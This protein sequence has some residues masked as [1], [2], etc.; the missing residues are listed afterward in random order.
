MNERV[1]IKK[2]QPNA[3]WLY[4]LI[5]DVREITVSAIIWSLSVARVLL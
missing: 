3:I 2:R 5:A 1:E 4:K